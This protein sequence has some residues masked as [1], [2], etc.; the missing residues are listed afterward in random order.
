MSQQHWSVECGSLRRAFYQSSGAVINLFQASRFEVK[1]MSKF[2]SFKSCSTLSMN[3]I[4]GSSISPSSLVLH[5]SL[6]FQ[7][8]LSFHEAKPLEPSLLYFLCNICNFNCSTLW[9]AILLCT[10][11]SN[12]CSAIQCGP[13]CTR[14]ILDGWRLCNVDRWSY[15]IQPRSCR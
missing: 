12:Q 5:L 4:S 7:D 13:D 9:N 3:L 15:T 11:S 1:L 14:T 2:F 10:T 6:A 8:T